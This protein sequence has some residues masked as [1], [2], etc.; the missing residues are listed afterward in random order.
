MPG[1]R[2]RYDGKVPT[3]VGPHPETGYQTIVEPGKLL[4]ADAPA[5]LRDEL[6]KRDRWT[7]VS[8]GGPP[9]KKGA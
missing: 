1:T 7:E 8:T 3:K 2:V 9:A 4:P 5:P 6:A